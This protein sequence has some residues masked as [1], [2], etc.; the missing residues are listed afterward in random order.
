MKYMKNIFLVGNIPL[1][2]QF[3][4]KPPFS[5]GSAFVPILLLK[6]VFDT[7]TSSCGVGIVMNGI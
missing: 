1:N 6:K 4:E 5:W 2:M 7:I 3:F